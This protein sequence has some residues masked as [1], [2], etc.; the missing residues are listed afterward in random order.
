M[1]NNGVDMMPFLITLSLLLIIIMI[2]MVRSY[3]SDKHIAKAVRTV[4]FVVI[5]PVLANMI[6]SLSLDK[7]SVGIAYQIYLISTDWLLFAL[8]LFTLEYC[9]FNRTWKTFLLA[10]ILL[11][12]TISILLNQ[13]FGHVYELELISTE[14]G[15]PYY[16]LHSGV[17]HYIHLALSFLVMFLLFALIINKLKSTSRIYLEKYFV[18]LFVLAFV[19]VWE[20]YYI[21]FKVPV[22]KS[23]IG[24]EI[25][26]VLIY[27]FGVE[28]QQLLLRYQMFKYVIARTSDAVFFFDESFRCIYISPGAY[29]MFNIEQDDFETPEKYLSQYHYARNPLGQDMVS[30]FVL[31]REDGKHTFN[32]QYKRVYDKNDNILGAF[33]ILDDRTEEVKKLAQ[34]RYNATHDSLTGLYD[35]NY[36][37]ERMAEKLK[38]V[39]NGEY[40]LVVSDIREFKVINDLFGREA[41]DRVLTRIAEII[42]TNASPDEIYGRIGADNFAVIIAKKNFILDLFIKG[43]SDQICV[44]GHPDYK[45]VNQLGIYEIKDTTISVSSM[46]DRAYM[47]VSTIKYGSGRKFAYYDQDIRDDII[48]EQ[49][50]TGSVDYAISSGQ[51]VPY[52]QAQVNSEGKAEGAEMLVRWIHPTEGM[53]SPDRFIGILEKSGKIIEIDKFM[54]ESACK[55]IKKWRDEG[56]DDFYLSVNISPKD[57][58]YADLYEVFTDLIDKYNIEAKYLRLEITESVMMSDMERKLEVIDKLRDAGFILEIDDFGSGYSSLN[59]LKD[60]PVDVLKIDMVFLRQTK[61]EKKALII[62]QQI[63]NMAQNLIIPVITEGVETEEQL[64]YLTEMGC[65]MFQGYYFSRPESLESFENKY[66][67]E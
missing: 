63:I 33:V 8:L 10:G 23:M 57:F 53:V 7:L 13:A 18:I 58:Y 67:S 46:L 27:F 54:W 5:F 17:G 56:K 30:N 66:M 52:F 60:M 15:R 20:A 36:F 24:Y 50:I 22:D 40:L 3:F 65:K 35:D 47:A 62:L 16:I 11:A 64:N 29:D 44:E 38:T 45:I 9:D 14:E 21:F 51:I 31:T 61:N 34:E 28:Y 49:T 41:G 39:N 12:D 37:R 42:R 4:L 2:L 48:W 32:V 43:T 55:T 59:L 1:K 25:C 6:I 26:A 19:S